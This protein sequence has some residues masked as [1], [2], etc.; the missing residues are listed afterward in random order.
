ML[1][2][3]PA[4]HDCNIIGVYQTTGNALVIKDIPEQLSPIMAKLEEV[5]Q[6]LDKALQYLKTCDD[7]TTTKAKMSFIK[8]VNAHK[9][10]DD[11]SNK[12]IALHL[13]DQGYGQLF[14]RIWNGLCGFLEKEKWKDNGYKNLRYMLGGYHTYGKC[15]PELAAE[16]GKNGSIP[17]LFAGLGKLEI[18]FDDEEEL[19][20]FITRILFFSISQCSRNRKIYQDANAFAIC[21]KYLKS[22]NRVV[23]FNSMLILAYVVDE[24]ESGILA[25][26][27][28]GIARLVELL[29]E[30]IKS[31]DHKCLG[32]TARE[33]LDCLNHLAMNDNNKLEIEK[34]GGIP[35]I[36]RML[37]DEFDE[38]DHC[39]AAEAVWN[40]AFVESIRTSAQLQEAVPLLDKLRSSK[41][42]NLQK[43]G[44]IA[45][46]EINDNRPEDLPT[47]ESTPQEHPP[48]YEETI[49]EPKRAA[50]NASN[51]MISYQ[52]DFKDIA[53]K[54]RDDLVNNGYRVWMDLT[55]MS[56]TILKSTIKCFLTPIP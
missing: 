1:Q 39:V 16:L 40:L 20:V 28:G 54:I 56:K 51:V 23:S 7:Y 24:S 49:K 18:Y 35:A 33:Y 9:D 11:V 21:K 52:W 26:S 10:E 55:H 27:D 34:E 43:T 53:L 6:A 30:A 42:R 2:K 38:E 5:K 32:S 36:V 17:L 8:I 3:Y 45:F 25:T 47:R 15:C 22:K 46:W 48:S 19:H 29:Q 4:I 14:P 41:N 50:S 44:S 13:I 12:Q 31:S 37:Q